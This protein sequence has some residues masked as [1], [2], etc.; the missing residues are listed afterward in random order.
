MR[1]KSFA[2]YASLLVLVGASGLVATACGGESAGAKPVATSPA[3]PP[4]PPATGPAAEADPL[5]PRPEVEPPPLFTPPTPVVFRTAHGINVWLLER[6]ALPLVA[7]DVTIPV[8]SASDPG[9]E[10]GLAWATANMLDEGA[11]SRGALEFARAV[12]Q[13]GASLVPTAGADHSGVSLFVLKRNLTPAF[14]LL[15][16]MVIRPRF[17]AVEWKR[18]HDLWMNDLRT[19][20]REPRAVAAIAASSALYGSDQPYGHPVSGTTTSAGKIDLARV[21]RFYQASWRPESVTVVAVGDISRAE[22][23]TLLDQ[24]FADWKPAPGAKAAP[25]SAPVE[26]KGTRPRLIVVDRADAPQSQLY[27]I[28]PGPAVADPD[29]TLLERANIALG[30]SFS[31]RLNLDLR[32]EHGWTYGAGSRVLPMRRAGSVVLSSAVHTENTG[33]AVKALLKDAELYATKGLTAGEVDLTRMTSRAELVQSYEHLSGAA[34]L[35]A[36]DA[37]L[38]LSPTYEAEAAARRDAATKA[39]LDRVALRYFHPKDAV[40]VIVG[41]RAKVLPQLEGAGLPKPEFFDTEGNPRAAR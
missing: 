22:L 10:G 27:V 32:E 4:A 8:G 24:S 19:R 31:S 23:S 26:P 39:D 6:H 2:A 36:A 1:R 7:I 13:L 9:G 40:I 38:G 15:A 16:D 41:P 34:S 5:G 25:P 28:R 20:T 33:D 18:V 21:K 17:D 14:G 11:G 29:A 3:K 35:L 30:G 12:D 37:A